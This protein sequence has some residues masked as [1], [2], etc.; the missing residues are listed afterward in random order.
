[1]LPDSVGIGGATSVCGFGAAGVFFTEAVFVFFTVAGF[2]VASPVGAL[3][4]EVADA[5]A[6]AAAAGAPDA[7]F[8]AQGKVSGFAA[9]AAF[10]AASFLSAARER[11]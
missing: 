11:H 10:F 8:A 3:E 7:A 1:V 6:P 5:P 9:L 4:V 2:V